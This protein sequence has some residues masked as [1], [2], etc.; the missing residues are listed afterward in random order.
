MNIL[1][2]FPN[3]K[4]T[5]DFVNRVYQ[6][7][8]SE[9]QAF[10]IY[11]NSS[12]IVS[13]D[14]LPY[15][16]VV[17]GELD[18]DFKKFKKMLKSSNRIVLHGLPLNGYYL[19]KLMLAL[20]GYSK[21]ILWSVWGADLYNEYKA[22]HNSLNPKKI[23]KEYIRKKLIGNLYGIIATED[24]EEVKKRYK[25]NAKQ[26]VATYSYKLIELQQTKKDDDFVNIMVGHSAT[27]T[28]R[29]VKTFEEL[30]PY[31]DKIRVY[32]PLSYPKN[33]EY[34]NLVINKGKELFGENFCPMTEFMAYD[35]YVKFLNKID[36]GIFNNDRQQ[37]NGNV[38]N[39]LYLG[40]KVYISR[41]NNLL[42]TYKKLGALINTCDEINLDNFLTPYPESIKEK[43]REVIINRY[44]DKTFYKNWT[45]VFND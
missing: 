36:I 25:T 24:Y 38:T 31:K 39:L 11:D 5:M 21:P 19:L 10:F 6:Q 29:H 37:G 8:P 30:L 13:K 23:Y 17:F 16:N 20:K 14:D 32:C 28:C 12:A 27:D 42:T 15:E 9:E 3:E 1:H 41:E 22:N 26:F 44:S 2:A 4:F 40:K 45:A 18:T 35:D 7:F 34:I 33:Q 43:N